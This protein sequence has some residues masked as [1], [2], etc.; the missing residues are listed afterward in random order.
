LAVIDLVAVVAVISAVGAAVRGVLFEARWWLALRDSRPAERPAIIRALRAGNHV[1][2]EQPPR[3][4]SV[5][6]GELITR[7]IE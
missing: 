5:V 6:G 7:W 3:D 2:R 4:T 1:A